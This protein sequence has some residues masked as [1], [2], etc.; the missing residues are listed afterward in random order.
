MAEIPTIRRPEK[1]QHDTRRRTTTMRFR[2]GSGGEYWMRGGIAWP[3]GTSKSGILNVQGYAVLCG[4]HV[5]TGKITVFEDTDFNTIE[6]RLVNDEEG[7]YREMNKGISSWLNENWNRYFARSYWWHDRG[8]T[9]KG[10]RRQIRE[11][12]RRRTIAVRLMFH[13]AL[14]QDDG[15]PEQVLFCLANEGRIIM[16]QDLLQAI[17][18]ADVR[19]GYVSVQKQAVMCALVGIAQ[20]PW[21]EPK[22]RAA[23]E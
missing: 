14:W 12:E 9:H 11:A 8:L 10:Y 21:K 7:K 23:W 17:R 18:T 2:D 20:K 22:K 4:V 3:V 5:E 1:A 13:E 16:P 6:T 15:T 19:P